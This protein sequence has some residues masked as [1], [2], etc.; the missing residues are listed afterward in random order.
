[1]YISY[2]VSHNMIFFMEDQPEEL[3]NNWNNIKHG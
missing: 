3:A 2:L 1:M